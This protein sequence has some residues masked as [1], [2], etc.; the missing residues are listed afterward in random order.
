MRIFYFHKRAVYKTKLRP[1][2]YFQA[3]NERVIN[4]GRFTLCVEVRSSNG[5]FKFASISQNSQDLLQK[6]SLLILLYPT[7]F[8]H[9]FE[10]VK[11]CRG[12]YV[13]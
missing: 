8:Y 7:L 1:M 12:E 2:G 3:P 5:A 13:M 10:K 11:F 6:V 9:A 4:K